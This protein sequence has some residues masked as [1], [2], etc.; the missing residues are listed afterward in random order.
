MDKNI[1]VKE[2]NQISWKNLKG[3]FYNDALRIFFEEL[4]TKYH[5]E[6]ETTFFAKLVNMST[7]N[8]EPFHRW[9]RYREGYAGALVKEIL[10]R[11]PILSKDYFV[12][13]PMCGSGSSLV[14]CRDLG[15]DALGLD[16]NGY[17]VLVTKVKCYSFGKNELKII[18]DAIT[19]IKTTN[20]FQV[21]NDITYEDAISKYFPIINFGILVAI[22][23]WIEKEF[24]NSAIADF[25]KVALLAI[26][27]DCSDRKK[28]GNGL[29]T[30][31]APISNV[32][33]RFLSQLALMLEDVSKDGYINQCN[34]AAIDCS[35][36]QLAAASEVFSAETKKKLG[37]IIFSPPYANSFDY[38]ES[39]KLEM[40]FGGFVKAADLRKSRQRL[41]R[42]YRI[43][44]P[45]DLVHSIY[46]VETLSAEI[47]HKIPEKEAETGV[48]DGRTRLIPNMLRG[49]FE[50]MKTVLQEGY[51]ALGDGGTMHIVVD[52]SAYVGVPIATDLIFCYLA[53]EIG[54]EVI[55]V[56][57]CRKA[58][59][60][61][62]QLKKFP[63]LKSLLRES[64][65]NL[66][67]I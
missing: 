11:F 16:V 41:I 54:F 50:D 19:Q 32:S 7:A 47:I 14:A 13:D 36:L 51:N 1:L 60:S 61:G 29:A 9:V 10:K 63:Y 37:T 21:E 46:P 30:R 34:I 12:M 25:F 35:A 8:K 23:K 15:I 39:Y 31:P 40:I 3:V 59:T 45:K 48:R 17:A 66:R 20:P 42:S 56:T 55:S 57:N 22:N 52:Q 6:N 58:N 53:E 43:T 4:E 27:E 65:V 28:D 24:E 49:Y 18:Q 2:N 62:Q 33:E 44:K 5:V 26:L 64:I 38:F 67:K